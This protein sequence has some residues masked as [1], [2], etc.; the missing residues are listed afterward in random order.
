MALFGLWQKSVDNKELPAFF[1]YHRQVLWGL[2][3]PNLVH[4]GNIYTGSSPSNPH[5][6]CPALP[7][8]R[9]KPYSILGHLSV[10]GEVSVSCLQRRSV[11]GSPGVH[12]LKWGNPAQ[13]PCFS[14]GHRSERFPASRHGE[15]QHLGDFQCPS[16][17]TGTSADLCLC[18]KHG[19]VQVPA[20]RHMAL[21]ILW[22]LYC[23]TLPCQDPCC[24]W[25][26][27]WKCRAVIDE[28]NPQARGAHHPLSHI[29]SFGDIC[30]YPHFLLFGI[31]LLCGSRFSFYCTQIMI[32]YLPQT[33]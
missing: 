26:L 22:V 10:N 9:D 29:R 21:R 3:G 20:Q 11:P 5:S 30:F 13:V 32:Q 4:P 28:G 17:H 27:A 19:S 15:T 12:L 18:V 8:Y 23:L 2:E 14:Q 16:L 1:S 25:V 7:T 6:T 24:S 33:T 31:E